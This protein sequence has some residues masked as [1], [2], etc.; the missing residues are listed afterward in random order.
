MQCRNDRTTFP[1]EVLPD[2]SKSSEE[3][4][5]R[6]ER[7]KPPYLYPDPPE[8]TAFIECTR[9]VHEPLFTVITD[10]GGQKQG[11]RTR[12]AFTVRNQRATGTVGPV[13]IA[14]D[15]RRIHCAQPGG[16]VRYRPIVHNRLNGDN[17][18]NSTR[19]QPRRRTACAAD[20][21]RQHRARRSQHVIRKRQQEKFGIP[22]REPYFCHR[23]G[24]ATCTTPQHQHQIP[25]P[26]P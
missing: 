22:N 10:S 6:R 8:P 9:S 21:H 16:R 3:K 11:Q 7:R 1:N 4:R 15:Q 25:L 23:T 13:T 17:N 24:Y 12:R 14:A 2:F 20:R 18:E 5:R 19:R 26:D